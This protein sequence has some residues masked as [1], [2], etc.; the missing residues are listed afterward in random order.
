M[1]RYSIIPVITT[2]EDPKRRYVVTKY[3][4]IS[5]ESSDIYVYTTKGDRYDLLAQSYYNDSS[6]WWII[7]KANPNLTSLDTIYPNPGNQIRIP[8]PSRIA[9]IIGTYELLN[10]TI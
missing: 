1:K 9:S 6:L 10:K 5:R 2:P 3:P 4:E 8:S 7:S